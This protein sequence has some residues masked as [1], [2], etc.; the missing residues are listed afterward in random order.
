MW[1]PCM[2]SGSF[3]TA[4]PTELPVCEHMSPSNFSSPIFQQS[5]KPVYS[6][7]SPVFAKENPTFK[8][9][10]FYHDSFKFLQKW[11][12]QISAKELDI[13]A[14]EPCIFM[15]HVNETYPASHTGN[16]VRKV[17]FEVRVLELGICANEP[18]IFERALY[19]RVFEKTLTSNTTFPIALPACED[20]T[21]LH[22]TYLSHVGLNHATHTGWRRCIGCVQLQV[23][24]HKRATNYRSL[25]Q[26]MTYEDKAS[27]ASSPPC[28]YMTFPYTYIHTYI[29]M[30]VRIH[31][32]ISLYIYTYIYIY[33]YPNTRLR[34]F[35]VL[36][37]Y[38]YF[39]IHIYMS[40][41]YTCIHICIYIHIYQYTTKLLQSANDIHILSYT[42]IHVTYLYM[43]TYKYIHIY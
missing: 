13:C 11:L 6:Q 27:Y 12:V 5:K 38:I 35:K 2:P 20:V 10:V 33:V 32:Y 9:H 17:E 28:V 24:F 19:F 40:L 34:G 4:L 15:W 14:K 29:Y 23:S 1:M 18:C 41:P 3:G 31:D 21:H 7:K 37:I 43:Y 16:T 39:L 36:M 8:Y 22:V 26:K 25:L 30:Y 42:Y